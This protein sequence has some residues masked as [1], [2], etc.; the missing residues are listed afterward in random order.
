M[1]VP[2]VIGR[3]VDLAD[4]PQLTDLRQSSKSGGIDQAAH[5]A[6]EWNVDTGRD[7]HQPA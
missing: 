2:V 1:F 6:G 3:R 5:T 4:K 7:A